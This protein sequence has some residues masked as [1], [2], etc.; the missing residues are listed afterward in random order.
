MRGGMDDVRGKLGERGE[1]KAIARSVPTSRGA[2]SATG[3][4]CVIV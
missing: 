1:I 2:C 3:D 4:S